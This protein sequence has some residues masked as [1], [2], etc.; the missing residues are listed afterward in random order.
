LAEGNQHWGNEKLFGREKEAGKL[1]NSSDI[2]DEARK[3]LR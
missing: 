1:A 2:V 3:H